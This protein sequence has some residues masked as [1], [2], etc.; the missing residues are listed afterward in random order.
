M[1]D[2]VRSLTKNQQQLGMQVSFNANL[3]MA[4]HY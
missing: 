2:E 1:E 3:F 4:S